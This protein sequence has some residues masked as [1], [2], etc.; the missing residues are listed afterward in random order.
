MVSDMDDL[1][2]YSRE[3]LIVTGMF[4]M[5]PALAP[6]TASALA[7]APTIASVKEPYQIP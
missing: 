2:N 4:G 7:V 5:A 6:T 3:L 1:I